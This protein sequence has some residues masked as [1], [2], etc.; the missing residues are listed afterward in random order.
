MTIPEHDF[1]SPRHNKIIQWSK[2]LSI[3]DSKKL[4]REKLTKQ[5]ERLKS[6]QR[7]PE[8]DMVNGLNGQWA[9]WLIGS[10]VDKL[11]GR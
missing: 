3:H 7:R 10:M 5:A 8:V 2:E 4:S 6:R 11:D 9:P 1:Y